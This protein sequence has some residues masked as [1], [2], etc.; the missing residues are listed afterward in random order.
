LR[1]FERIPKSILFLF[2]MTIATGAVYPLLITGIAQLVFP[3]EANGSLVSI[4]GEVRGSVLLSQKFESGRFFHARPSATD[5]AYA[6][7]G[8]SNAA[9]TSAALA[10]AVA[11]REEAWAAAFGVGPGKTPPDILYASASGLDPDISRE[12]AVQQLGRV[13]AER[14]F[15][16]SRKSALEAAIEAAVSDSATLVGPPRVNI[17]A[18]NLRLETDPALGGKEKE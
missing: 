11:D 6:G 4:G 14:G 8:G 10:K 13:A 16:A 15:D 2:W 17:A 3:A 9:P 1:I 12:A 18:L 5:Y 7:A